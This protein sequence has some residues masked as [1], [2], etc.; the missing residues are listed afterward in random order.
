MAVLMKRSDYTAPLFGHHDPSLLFWGPAVVKTDTSEG[1]R[2][3]LFPSVDSD[4]EGQAA[5]PLCCRKPARELHW[6]M[7]HPILQAEVPCMCADPR[8][9]LQHLVLTSSTQFGHEEKVLGLLV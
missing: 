8:S 4:V 7:T 6:A 5:I 3:I 2:W 1:I 9:H